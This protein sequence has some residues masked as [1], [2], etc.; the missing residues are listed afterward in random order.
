MGFYCAKDQISF[1]PIF[2]EERKLLQELEETVGLSIVLR[3]HD[4]LLKGYT[5]HLYWAALGVQFP[6]YHAGT[7]NHLLYECELRTGVGTHFRYRKHYMDLL[8]KWFD[9]YPETKN[10]LSVGKGEPE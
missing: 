3:C 1:D 8:Q 10:S 9:L 6:F 4:R 5:N 7:A 2:L